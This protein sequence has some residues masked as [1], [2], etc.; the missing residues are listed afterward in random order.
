MNKYFRLQFAYSGEMFTAECSHKITFSELFK[1]LLPYTEEKFPHINNALK[2][3]LYSD[4]FNLLDGETIESV[5]VF[6]ANYTFKTTSLS[7]FASRDC[8]LNKIFN[9][10]VTEIECRQ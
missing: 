10:D 1:K 4:K 8:D 5:C 2:E 9:I 7:F 3:R 6:S